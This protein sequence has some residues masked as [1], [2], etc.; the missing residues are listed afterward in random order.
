MVA[1]F[2]FIAA[3]DPVSTSSD[4]ED[5][6]REFSVYWPHVVSTRQSEFELEQL[7][8]LALHRYP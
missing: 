2:S 7:S 4:P 5:V 8:R 3:A 6:W 1:V